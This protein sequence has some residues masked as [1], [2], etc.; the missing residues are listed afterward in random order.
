[1]S[2]ELTPHEA[3]LACACFH[4][5]AVKAGGY[6]SAAWPDAIKDMRTVMLFATNNGLGTPPHIRAALGLGSEGA[7]AGEVKPVRPRWIDSSWTAPGPPD[8]MSVGQRESAESERI[9]ALSLESQLAAME[10]ERDAARAELELVKANYAP[11]LYFHFD[12]LSALKSK[13]ARIAEEAK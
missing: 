7:K 3:L 11:G 5:N 2:T 8:G 9:Y 13:L 4:A 1:M 12:E 6:A 10:K